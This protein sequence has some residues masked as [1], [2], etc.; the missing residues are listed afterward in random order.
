MKKEEHDSLAY[1]SEKDLWCKDLDDF[2]QEWENQLKEDADYDKSIRNTNRRHSR[3]IGAGKSAGRKAASKN[4]DDY[5]PSMAK[6]KA[7]T[8]KADPAKGIV[9]VE[10]KSNQR[11]A[12]MFAAK[13]KSKSASLDGAD[14]SEGLSDDDFEALTSKPAPKSKSTS[15]APSEQPATTNGRSKRTA[16][17]APKNWIVDGDEDSESSD[18]LGDI[19]QMVKGIGGIPAGD[20]ASA[21]GRVSLFAMSRLDSSHGGPPTTNPALPKIKTKASRTFDISDNDETNYEMLARSSPHKTAPALK[22]DLDSFLSDEEDVPVI[23]KKAAVPKAAVKAVPKQKKISPV[24]SDDDGDS[25]PIV[26]KRVPAVKAVPK[27]KVSAVLSDDDE[28]S[29]PVVKKKV[30]TVISAPKA[31]NESPL[32]IMSDDTSD[33]DPIPPK[34]AAPKAAAKPV[35]KPAPKA[36]KAA[37]PLKPTALSPAA[38]AYA[39]KQNKSKPAKEDFSDEDSDLDMD[40]ASPPPKPAARGRPA[41]A[42]AAAKPKKPVYVDSEDDDDMEVDDLDESALVEDEDSEDDFE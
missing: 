30:L 1:M 20:K 39:A 34:K 9:K 28:D 36:K 35:A 8:S 33:E 41:R 31:K 16:A 5:N 23:A 42:A 6:A 17:A 7:K 32:V 2:V 13:P 22:D 10:M 3:K 26:K 24:L 12:D 4:D 14:D 38:K 25:E 40:D 37:A 29:E 18:G 27:K 21:N 15:R 11:F 19:D